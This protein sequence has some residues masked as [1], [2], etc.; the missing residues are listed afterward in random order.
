MALR[1][2]TDATFNRKQSRGVAELDNL[3]TEAWECRVPCTIR[4]YAAQCGRNLL[5]DDLVPQSIR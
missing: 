2:M 5:A 4:S 1:L 3:S